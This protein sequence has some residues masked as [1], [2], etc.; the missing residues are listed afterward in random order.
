MMT[1]I[2]VFVALFL[3]WIVCVTIS[4]LRSAKKF[5]EKY[6]PID[7]EEF[8]RRCRPGVRRDVALGVRRIV[9]TSLDIEYER[10]YPEQR[11]VE[12][13]HVD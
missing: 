2:W 6:P 11:F 9:A 13:L 1:K 7:D 10:V 4:G 3:L 12:D 5:R 8:L